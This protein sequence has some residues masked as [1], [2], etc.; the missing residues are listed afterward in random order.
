MPPQLSPPGSSSYSSSTL[1]VG[2]GTWQSSRKT[3]LLPNL[4]GFNFATTRYNGM[5]NR[6]AGLAQYHAI[7][8]AHGILGAL[9]FLVIVPA[10][11]LT[12]RFYRR[13]PGWALRL[14]IWLQI[15]TV[16]LTTVVFVLGWFA[17][18]PRRSLSNP[19]HSIGLAIYVLVLVQAIGGWFVH[20]REKGKSRRRL[21]MKLM[22][23]QWFGRGIALLGLA[24][25]PMGLALY[26]SPA[27][28]FVLYALAAFA[29]LVTYFWLCYHHQIVT[30]YAAST[31]YGSTSEVVEDR[32]RGR[33]AGLGALGAAGVA[34][35]GLAA[36]SHFRHRSRSR[37]R[38]HSRSRTDVVGSRP[39]SES[40]I[41]E[42][43]SRDDRGGGWKG[44]LLKVG[45]LAGGAAL[46]KNLLDRR[47]GDRDSYR[48]ATSVDGSQAYTQDSPSR[49][50]RLEEGNSPNRGYGRRQHR[51]SE[52]YDS[53]S[54]RTS[55]DSRGRSRRHQAGT[56]VATLGAL[57]LIRS[58]FKGRRERKEQRRVDDLR[59]REIEEEHMARQG[60]NG[61]RFTG[62][63]F[64][65][66]G[67]RRGSLTST[68]FTPPPRGNGGQYY[69]HGV[70]PPVPTQGGMSPSVAIQGTAMPGP[71]GFPVLPTAATG[72]ANP[73][74]PL[75]IPGGTIDPMGV[76]HESSGSETYFSEGGR[77]HRR[78]R[79]ST[80]Y[81]PGFVPG[82]G[83]GPSS[84]GL[85]AGGLGAAATNSRL[86]SGES[87]TSPPI[88]VKVKYHGDEGRHVT[89]RRLPEQEAANEREARRR[90]RL[91][92]AA[93][94]TGAGSRG[95]PRRQRR[96]RGDSESELA[97]TEVAGADWRR[98]EEMERA[99][100]EEAQRHGATAPAPGYSIHGGPLPPAA[101]IPM[102]MP[103]GGTAPTYPQQQPMGSSPGYVP[104]APMS[105]QQQQQQE[106]MASAAATA[107]NNGLIPPPPIPAAGG[108]GG[109][110]G[111]GYAGGP[112]GGGGAGSVGSPGTDASASLAGGSVIPG[113]SDYAKSSQRRRAERLANRS[114]AAPKRPRGTVEFE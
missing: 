82:T 8:R 43:Y 103:G 44:R 35:A 31:M 57:G 74:A 34:S 105:S 97:E 39:P 52:S 13:R 109:G 28:L 30:D 113:G 17:V 99:Q 47:H 62:D 94:G 100:A 33:R 98:V 6:F 26:G 71:A 21:P 50:S 79:S 45:A 90:E 91:Q 65:R 3:F 80:T 81:P 2:D 89:L 32:H 15:L 77:Q 53:T 12:A 88:S 112:A 46:V 111:G 1:S 95:R 58:A 22:L 63:G 25:V 86:Q 11:I 29:L 18:G 14:H 93:V 64:P 107:R 4:V 56:G 92:Q 102:P 23:H 55:F 70:P 67:G 104:Q 114:S 101:P 110:G 106:A 68:D 108:G 49:V 27:Y 7:V 54:D 24:Q 42:K 19:H 87:Q 59:R 78:H 66:R 73:T 72:A 41:S 69:H 84:S 51:R 10:A 61:R 40:Y 37:S 38:S 20:S 85:A 83:A 75:P 96:R 48:P 5:G 76:L 60:S 36:F 16:L 9:V